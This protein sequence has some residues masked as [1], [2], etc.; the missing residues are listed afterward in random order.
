MP[1]INADVLAQVLNEVDE[2]VNAEPDTPP[3]RRARSYERPAH[4]PIL[5][6]RYRG[7]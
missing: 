5:I 4:P 6:H 1:N 3:R 7:A 2:Q